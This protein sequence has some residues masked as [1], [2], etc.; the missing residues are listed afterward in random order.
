MNE[1]SSRSPPPTGSREKGKHASSVP[2]GP[3]GGE[4][5]WFHGKNGGFPPE[6][7]GLKMQKWWFN[8]LIW[9]NEMKPTK[10][11]FADWDD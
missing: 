1:I 2:A 11:V 4:K 6:N 10:M 5:W 3:G 9:F 8:S 7:G